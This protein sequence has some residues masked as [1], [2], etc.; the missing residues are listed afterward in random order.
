MY[1]PIK[2]LLE[3]QG[4]TVK[5]EVI[6]CDVAAA[7]GD[8]LWV[9]EMKMNFNVTLLYQ[10][11]ERLKITDRVF[12]AVPRPRS[13]RE[14]N[15]RSMLKILRK[16]E[17]GLI[18]VSLDSPLRAAEIILFPADK[19]NKSNKASRIVKNEMENRLGDT[20]GGINKAGSTAYR[21]RCIRVACLLERN[22]PLSA[23]KL[24]KEFNCGAETRGVLYNNFYNW[25]K[26]EE[27]GIYFLSETGIDYL[28]LN[29]N[30]GVVAYYR[31]K[32]NEII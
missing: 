32:A 14:K 30:N 22:G 1:P 4:F 6:K 29:K 12:V 2:N 18:T 24:I 5:G 13:E 25:F 3:S 8:A 28:E 11:M 16:L 23:A 7:K 15:Y 27:K 21:E 10:A 17:L 9:V 20:A 26:K 19:K 31:M